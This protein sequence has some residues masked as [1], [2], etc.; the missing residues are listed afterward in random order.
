MCLFVLQFLKSCRCS[1]AL[2]MQARKVSESL[3][4]TSPKECADYVISL[5]RHEARYS[6]PWGVADD[7]QPERA[8]IFVEAQEQLVDRLV[9]SR[10][11]RAIEQL[12]RLL[13]SGE[14]QWDS[15]I[16]ELLWEAV[17]ASRTAALPF[18]DT[19]ARDGSAEAAKMGQDIRSLK[20]REPFQHVE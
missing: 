6:C 16:G 11:D 13:F 19:H 8:I 9:S 3:T 5:Q 14:A 4:F 7:Y 12:A 1:G 20:M 10:D 2:E 15:G 18:V 17:F